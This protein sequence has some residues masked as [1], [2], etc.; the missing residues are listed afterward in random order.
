MIMDTAVLRAVILTAAT[1][2]ATPSWAKVSPEEAAQ[3]GKNLTPI[4]AERAGNADG[5]IP[6]WKPAPQRG[7]IKPMFP[8]N[9]DIDGDKILF[10]IT[11]A[12]MAQYADKL[13]EGHKELL[14]RYNTY[15]LNVY[16]SRRHASFPERIYEET[17]K[18]ATRASLN[19]VDN[20][21]GAYI[22]FPFP[23][24]KTGTEPLWNHRA[25]WRSETIRRSN[26]QM[27]VQQDGKFT[28]TKIVEDVEFVYASLKRNPPLE[29]KPGTTFI[30]YLSETVAPPRIA[31]TYILVHEK[32]GFGP[33]G[34]AAWLYAPALK[35]IRRAPA[36]CCDNPYE[37]TDGHQFYDQVDMYNGVFERFTWKLVGKKEMFIPVNGNKLA[38][39]TVKYADMA[40][41]NHLNSDLP[42][43]ELRRVW[44][45]EA[46]N[47]PELRHTFKFRRFYIDEDTWNT[48]M[49]DNYDQQGKLMQFQEGHLVSYQNLQVHT[50]IPEVIYHFNS[51]R[52][53]VTAMINEDQPYDPTV[54]YASNFFDANTVQSRAS[55]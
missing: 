27:I 24:P 55:K 42:R 43:Y 51:G 32:A 13:S 39:P 49:V 45:V 30:N 25:K 11:Q 48:V 12:N 40:R 50:T 54:T 28:L 19:G 8:S 33:E 9:P 46:E 35:R 14:R 21:S 31:G 44:I 17:I 52:Y 34:R 7:E 23:I 47:R 26:N 22:G 18:N 3:L 20:P 37:G 5:T 41:P 29:L 1:L 2:A 4:G 36:V 53:F 16:P 38:G 10:T 6:E 15:K